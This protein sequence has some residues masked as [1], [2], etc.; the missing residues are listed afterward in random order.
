MDDDR[1]AYEFSH[2]LYLARQ[3]YREAAQM[4]VQA[5]EAGLIQIDEATDLLVELSRLTSE[6]LWFHYDN[7]GPVVIGLSSP[8]QKN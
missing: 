6:R 2:A 8:T 1:E 3:V 7:G 5:A 4:I